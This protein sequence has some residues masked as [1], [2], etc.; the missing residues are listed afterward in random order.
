MERILL[1]ILNFYVNFSFSTPN[2]KYEPEI[3]NSKKDL[4]CFITH[5]FRPIFLEQ[6]KKIN[7][8]F[9]DLDVVILFDSSGSYD[10]KIDNILDKIKI[11]KLNK[12]RYCS[13]DIKGGHSLFLNFLK[14][15]KHLIANYTNIWCIFS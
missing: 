5:N 3:N 6:L 4:C 11:K 15:N 8:K 14:N 12:L 13:Y 1:A 10:K 7:K 2:S 9:V